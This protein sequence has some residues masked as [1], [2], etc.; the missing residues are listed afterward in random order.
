MPIWF[1]KR[2]LAR[3]AVEVSIKQKS[4]PAFAN[5]VRRKSDQ[6]DPHRSAHRNAFVH[7]APSHSLFSRS[8]QS[9]ARL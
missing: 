4:L 2:V 9:S 8:R 3:V 5:E 6:D 7:C 1:R